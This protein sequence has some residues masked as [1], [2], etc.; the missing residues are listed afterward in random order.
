MS[1]DVM[2]QHAALMKRWSKKPIHKGNN[3]IEDGIIDLARWQ[4]ADRKILFLLKE[5][6]GDY[7]NLCW[8]IKDEWNGPKYKTWKTVSYWL[9]GLRKMQPDSIPAFPKKQSEI[10][11]CNEF[12]LSSAVVNVKKSKG[13]SS[14]DYDD[15]MKYTEEDADL[16]R[17]QILLINPEI[18]VCGYTFDFFEKFWRES[19]TP[20]GDTEFVSRTHNHII[21][22]FWHPANHYPDDMCYYALC[23][24][25]KNANVF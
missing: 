1:D 23:A 24:V 16:L 17:E 21:V 2:S 9:Y 3:F 7:E 6:Y 14:S 5:A 19:I 10:D 25:M 4:K 15:I 20:V 11:E 22:N 18:I 12:L 13:T 8:L